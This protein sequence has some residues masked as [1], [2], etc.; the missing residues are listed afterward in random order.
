MDNQNSNMD[1]LNNG[2]NMSQNNVL[3][4]GMNIP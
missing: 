1:N 4:N 2:M 3:D